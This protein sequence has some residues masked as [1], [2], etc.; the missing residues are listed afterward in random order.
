M[1]SEE[2]VSVVVGGRRFT[3]WKSVSVS[4][5]L[6]EA[7]R[8]FR[9]EA[10]CE[11]GASASFRTFQAGAQVEIYF[12]ADLVLRGYVDRYQPRISERE[13]TVTISG[14]SKSADMIDSSAEYA[15]GKGRLE[16]KSLKQI[17]EKLDQ[18]GVGVEVG[19]DVDLDEIPFYQITPGET[20][21]RAV[22]RLARSQGLTVMG[23]ADG[24]IELA[25]GGKKRHS[26]G[27]VE[28]VNL[29]QGEADHNWS[30]RHSKYVV[31]GQRASGSTSENL[32]IEAAVKDTGVDRYR[33]TVII[34]GEDTDQ[35][36]A[37]RFAEAT[38]NRAAGNA[39]KATITLQ[40][41]RDDGGMVW[42]PNRLIWTESDFL[43]IQQDMLIES[44]TYRQDERGSITILSLVDPKAYD[45]GADP[46]KS[47]RR[48][49]NKSGSEWSIDSGSAAP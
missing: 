8:A 44:V 36:R 33:P 20:V 42:E 17:A 39:L 32:E 46:K 34:V 1:P 22:E 31:K 30:N 37:Q 14:R 43:Q 3:S 9:L 15:V 21:F 24:K 10:A 29:K 49:L 25:R 27:I 6:K 48:G 18:F 47:K 11:I 38:R 26:G 4:A 2:T 41:F 40:G 5:A 23:R 45:A 12:N 13:A 7:A 35:N 19:D 16:R 28:G